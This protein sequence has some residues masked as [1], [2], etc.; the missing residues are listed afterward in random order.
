MSIRFRRSIKIAPGLRFSISKTGL[1]L[2]LGIPG[3][4][5]S[6]NTQGDIY[7][8]AGIPGTGLYGVERTSIRS[9]RG[10]RKE[11]ENRNYAQNLPTPGLF[12]PRRKKALYRAMHAGTRV[13]LERIGKKFPE[14][15][16]VCDA[17][18]FPKL[19]MERDLELKFLVD[20]ASKLWIRKSELEKEPLFFEFA[21]TFEVTLR[22]APGVSFQIEYGIEA[23]GLAYVELLQ[24]EGKFDSALAVAE[25][26]PAN[27]ATAL[28]VCESEVQLERWK[29]VLETTEEVENVDDATALLLIYR[30]VALRELGL[31][32]AAIESLKRA[33]SSRSRHDDVL[34]KALLERAICYQKLGKKSQA[35][36]DLE[37]IIATDSDFPGVSEIITTI[38]DS[39]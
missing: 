1:G 6:I 23:M 22:A 24:L 4:R 18:V 14:I 35:L 25:S 19:L 29:D 9:K 16:Y 17:L 3:A 8:S 36:R 28:A 20:L 10:R 12:E 2:S 5:A 33:R 31:F 30:A 15:Q 26:L 7:A 34:N 21:R 38:R 27:Q 39:S 37:R 32:D 13:E 11:F